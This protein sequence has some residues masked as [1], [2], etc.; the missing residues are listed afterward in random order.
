V[1]AQS[2]DQA[3]K[4]DGFIDALTAVLALQ[5]V[6]SGSTCDHILSKLGE[7]LL[8]ILDLRLVVVRLRSWPDGAHHEV[9]SL[10]SRYRDRSDEAALIAALQPWLS[11]P[12]GSASSLNYT[13]MGPEVISITSLELGSNG[14]WGRLVA[15]APRVSFP[16]DLRAAEAP[17]RVIV[18]DI[19]TDEGFAHQRSV[20]AEARVRAMQSTPLISHCGELLRFHRH[21]NAC[22]QRDVCQSRRSQEHRPPTRTCN[23]VSRHLPAKTDRT[24]TQQG[25]A[26]ARSR[27]RQPRPDPHWTSTK[28]SARW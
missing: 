18:E 10:D 12:L 7:A 13:P 8:R 2:V 22:R 14:A 4:L 21:L 9:L 26:G 17:S 1:N 3:R 28:S 16:S 27:R 5:S 24:D 6:S 11:P 15:G 25:P 23:R 20:A 19:D